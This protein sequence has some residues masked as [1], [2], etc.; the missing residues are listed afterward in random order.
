MTV[1]KI[2]TKSN[3]KHAQ[4]LIAKIWE[5]N[6]KRKPWISEDRCHT[7]AYEDLYLRHQLFS[8]PIVDMIVWV[9][10]DLK[11]DLVLNCM[12]VGVSVAAHGGQKRS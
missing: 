9:Y 7:D 6:E 5:Q 10:T 11:K 2:E 4:D 8:I 12:Y 3:S 1:P